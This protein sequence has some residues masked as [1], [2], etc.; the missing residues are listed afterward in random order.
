MSFELR[1]EQVRDL[2]KYLPCEAMAYG[3]LPLMITENCLVANGLGCRSRDL[4]GPCREGHVLTDRRGERFPILPAF[5][6]RS[7]IQNSKALF[8][9]DKPELGRCG[10]AYGRLRFTTETAAEC[11]RLLALYQGR[12]AGSPPEGFTRGLFYR[13]V[14]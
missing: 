2:R 1:W 13:G 14:E 9:A 11:V 7:E 8:L 3:R 6:C 5:G 10:L 4:R 12:E